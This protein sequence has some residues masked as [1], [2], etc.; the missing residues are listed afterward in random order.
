[1]KK[2]YDVACI[3]TCLMDISTPGLD[4]AAFLENEPNLAEGIFYS[5][6][7]DANN[8]AAV[9][10]RL[11]HKTCLLGCVGDDF[12]GKFLLDRARDDGVD[13]SRVCVLPGVQTAANNILIGA[14]DKR[15][16]T[17]SKNRTSRSELSGEQIDHDAIRAARAVSI[18]SIFVH[19]KLDRD[20]CG[21]LTLA[22]ENGAVTAADVCPSGEA[23]SLEPLKDAV[24]K[25]D[26]LFANEGE[27][28]YLS[29]EDTPDAMADYFLGLGVGT[30]I[31]K[32]GARG[33]L[34]KNAAER[35]FQPAIPTKNVVDT[36]G[37]G[38]CFAAGFLS[39]VLR[40]GSLAECARFATACSSL[41][42]QKVGATAAIESRAQVENYLRMR[43]TE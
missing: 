41:T 4:F 15:V 37:A 31:V 36:T 38:D 6:G 32:L 18:G 39:G 21:L 28:K 35:I 23:C 30:V 7:G 33:S 20:L 29:G 1:M 9:L 11:G 25:L 42:I 27:A 19:P 34:V 8:Q 10:S 2:R 5:T 12:V 22:K 3:G 17:I 26:F 14:N 13:V 24:A 40:G 16:Y 43:C